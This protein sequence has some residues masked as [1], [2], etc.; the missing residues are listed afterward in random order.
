MNSTAPSLQALRRR[1]RVAQQQEPADLVFR[2]ISWLDVFNLRWERGDVAVADGVVVGLEPGHRGIREVEGT[3]L[4]LVPGFIDGHVHIESSLMTPVRFSTTVVSR[5]TTTAVVDPHE[6]ANV[7]G[8]QGLHWVAEAA[9]SAAMD[10]RVQ[11]PSCVPATHLETSGATLDAASLRRL[12]AHPQVMGLA[13]MMNVPGVLAGAED[14]LEKLRSFWGRPLDGHSPLLTG[15]ALDAYLSVGIQNCHEVVT[16]EEGAEKLRKGMAV[17]LREGSVAKSLETL[18]PLVT[19]GS[20]PQIFFCT[21]D[22]N[23]FDIYREGHLDHLVRKAIKL[24]LDPALAFRLA[25][26]SAARH[27]GLRDRGAIAPGQ[28]ADLVVLSDLREVAV[29]RVFVEGV[30]ATPQH[31]APYVDPDPAPLRHSVHVGESVSFSPAPPHGRGGK[32]RVIGLVPDQII[33]RHLQCSYGVVEGRAHFD[34]VDVVPITVL[35][36]HGR[37]GFQSHGFVSGFGLREGAIATSVGHDSHN[38]L[39]IYRDEISARTCLAEINRCQGAF[40][41]SRGEEVL[42][43]LPLPLAGLMSEGTASEIHDGLVALK[44]AARALGCTLHEPFLQLAFLALPVIPSLKIT[45]RGLVD[46]EQ[47]EIVSPWI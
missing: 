26:W 47:F 3:G 43:S 28:R 5:G 15:T 41:V 30:E 39:I 37:G 34:D 22:R 29:Q 31:L 24:G 35:E 8:W 13:E 25:S 2:N 18:L 33:T 45:D 12:A 32:A 19:P 46:V 21:D 14:V 40:V 20:S 4:F 23:P 27:F 38:I 44:A 42:A 1:L 10:I 16:L 11:L 7:L 17:M 6:V 36:R 9:R